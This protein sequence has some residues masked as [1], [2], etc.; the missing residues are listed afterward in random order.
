MADRINVQVGFSVD[1]NGLTQ[2]QSLF[3]QIVNE[4]KKPGQ[5][6]NTGLQKAATTAR[7][8]D[9]ILEKTFNSD[10]GSLNVTKFNQELSKTGLSLKSIKNDFSNAGS[11]GSMAYNRLT[12]SILGTNIQLKQSNKLLDSMAVSMSNTVK[13]GITSSIFNTITQSISKAVTYVKQLD[14]SLNDIR[15]V[16][17]KSADNMAEFA[18]QANIAAKEMG[19]STLDYTNAALIYYQQGLSDE[20]T[21]ARAET[22]VKAANVT[23]QTGQEVSE[24][25]TAVW[26]GYKV[27]AEET[28]LYVDKLAAVA[29]TTA[30]DLE[31]LSVGMSKVAS[32]ANAMGVDFDDLNAQ[33]ATIVSVTRQAPESVG[34]AL[35]TI[36]ARLGDLKVDGVDEFGIK[37]GEV[38]SQLQAMGIDILDVNGD[39]R[40]M[41]SVMTE[42][43]E[44]W[45][46][47]TRSQQQAAAIAMAGKRQYNNLIAL[48]ENWDMYSDA[49]KTSTDAMGTLQHQQDIYMESTEA[50]LKTLK[51]TWQDLYGG[52]IKKDELDT[53]IEAL[54]NL[55]QVFDNFIDSFGG[56]IKSIS[57]FGIIIANIFNKQISDSINNAIQNQQRYQQNIDLLI[58]KQKSFEVGALSSGSSIRDQ[59]IQF[60]TQKELDIA[61]EI[62]AVKVGLNTEDYNNLTNMQQRVGQLSEEAK[63]IE[64]ITVQEEQRNLSEDK[65]NQLLTEENSKVQEILDKDLDRYNIKE[66]DLITEQKKVDLIE[67]QINKAVALNAQEKSLAG[68]K[69]VILNYARSIGKEEEEEISKILQNVNNTQDLKRLKEYI[70]EAASGQVEKEAAILNEID[71]EIAAENRVLEKREQIAKYQEEEL[72]LQNQINQ[73]IKQGAQ[74]AG[75]TKTVTTIT[76]SLSSMAMAWGSVNS[77]IDTLNDK[78]ASFGDKITQTFM[79]LGMTIPMMLSSFSKI[80]EAFNLTSLWDAYNAKV[81]ASVLAEKAHAASIAQVTLAKEADVAMSQLSCMEDEKEVGV[82]LSK[83]SAEQMEAISTG[84]QTVAEIANSI[85]NQEGIFLDEKQIAAIAAVIMAKNAEAAATDALTASEEASNFAAKQLNATLLASPIGW[86]LGILAAVVAVTAM[87]VK[88]QRELLQSQIDLNNATIERANKLQEEVDANEDLINE[89]N[90]LYSQYKQGKIEKE[91]LYETTDK[92]CD[93]Y[94]IE[95]GYLAKLTGDYDSLTDSINKAREAELESIIQTTKAEKAA[96][97]ANILNTGRQGLGYL[98]G[99]QYHIAF[100]SDHDNRNNIKAQAELREQ[101]LDEGSFGISVGTDAQS[102]IDLYNKVVQAKTAMDESMTEE[103]RSYSDTYQHVTEWIDKMTDS[104]EKLQNATEQLN[105]YKIQKIANSLDLSNTSSY[106]DFI[107]KL[108]SFRDKLKEEELDTELTVNELVEQYLGDL[109]SNY[110]NIYLGLKDLKNQID[111]SGQKY[112]DSLSEGEKEYLL[113]GKVNLKFVQ[114]AEDIQ[115]EL[116]LSFDNLGTFDVTTPISLGETLASGSKLK[117][118]DNQAIQGLI[119]ENFEAMA[120][121]DEKSTLHQLDVIDEITQHRIDKN[122]EYLQNF[123]EVNKK[124]QSIREEEKTNLE[125]NIEFRQL[126]AAEQRRNLTEEET[127]KLE[128]YRKKIQDVEEEILNLQEKLKEGLS[129]D[130]IEEIGFDSLIS[131]ID[132]VI[133]RT[134]ALQNAAELVGENFVVAASDVEKLSNVF[135]ELLENYTV[136]TDGSLQLDKDLVQEK[137]NGIKTEM[138]ARTEAKIAEI[139]QQIEL[140]KLEQE[141]LQKKLENLQTYLEGKQSEQATIDAINKAGQEYEAGLMALTG[142]EITNLTNHAIASSQSEGATLIGMLNQVGAGFAQAAK[143]H[144]AMINGENFEWEP[145][146]FSGTSASAQEYASNVGKQAQALYEK[147]SAMYEQIFEEAKQVQN[148]LNTVNGEID[149]LVKQK[150]VLQSTSSA[151]LHALDNVSSGKAGKDSKSKKGGGGK[152]KKDKDEKDYEKEFDR[153]WKI[154]KA[155]DAVD[156]ALKILEKDKKN[157][158]GYQLI[159]A[160]KYENKLLD[161][162][163]GYYKQLLDAQEQ[164]AAELRDQLGTMGLMFD[165]SGAIVNYAEATAKALAQYN[166][167]I[168]QY[169]AGLIDETTLGVYEKSFE[170]FKKL[171]ERYDTLYYKEIKDTKDKLDDIRR[172]ELENNL[173]AWEVEIKLKLDLKELKRGWNDFLKEISEDFQK[174][175]KD[176]TVETKRLMDD[177]KTYIGDDGSIKTIINAIH[178]VTHEIDVMNSGGKSTMFESIT[179]AQEKL[180]ELN[181]ELQDAAKGL[182]DLWK[183]AWDA[184]LDGIDQVSDKLEDLMNQFDRINDELEFQGELIELIYGDEAYELLNKLYKGQE[185][186]LGNQI[187]SLKLQVDMWKQLFE[188]TGAAMDNQ[189]NWT[190]DQKAY[191]DKWMDAQSDLNDLVIDYIKLLKEDYLNTVSLVLKELENAITGSSLD[192]VKTQWERIS[193]Y[194]DKYLD[195]VEG[196]YEIQKLA[197]KIDESIANTDNLKQQQKLQALREKEI[198]Y[199]REKEHLTQ[200][201]LDAAE[202]RYQIALKEMALEDARNNKTSMK[203]VRNE[204]GNWAYQYVADEA[205]VASKQQELLD[206]FNNL[207]Q[208]ASDAYE[209][210]LEALQELQEKYLESAQ[211]IYENEN[212][213]EQEKE[214]QL[215][216][217]REWYFEQYA[218]LAE[219]NTLY[220]N[221]LATSAAA[222]LLEIYEQDKEAYTALTEEER[223]LL[224]A[225]VQANIDDYMDLEEKMKENYFN[226]GD[227]SRT[228]MA[229]TRLDWT[230]TAQLLADLWN[231]DAGGSVRYEVLDAYNRIQR[232]TNDYKLQLDWLAAAAAR[233]FGPEG[234]TG[235]IDQA[236]NATDN[237]NLKTQ[238]LVNDGVYYLSILKQAVDQIAAAWQSVQN[239]IT[240]AISLLEKYISMISHW[241]AAVE[242]NT[243]RQGSG[244]KTTNTVSSG[245]GSGNGGGGGGTPTTGAGD[246]SQYWTQMDRIIYHQYEENTAWREQ[247]ARIYHNPNLHYATG[248]YTGSWASGDTDGRLAVLHQKEIVLNKDDTANFLQAIN[249]VRDLSG[250]NDSI[251][252]TI[253]NSIASMVTSMINPKAKTGN[254]TIITENSSEKNNVFNI[255]AEFPNANDVNEIR[256]A[257]MSLPNMASQYIGRNV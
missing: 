156:R 173:K 38:S 227:A 19:A 151:A 254:G 2:M 150:A 84:E 239:E 88:R 116:Q 185:K 126:E 236:A 109:D 119:D 235:A 36:Y 62:Y 40:D 201:D 91:A 102:L 49:L 218:L 141:Y 146:N 93:L 214:E 48:F 103:E 249:T 144:Y 209:A 95:G 199:L 149:E 128:E 145:L 94:N 47:W 226:I 107:N 252:S 81:T 33:I 196:A 4:A 8:L 232:A 195:D 73:G 57:A 137:V 181:D 178:D 220:R 192:R 31:E 212:L 207:Y 124:I 6:L 143:A 148:Q 10:L 113:S 256:E 43:A 174:V 1:K 68:H 165:A 97:E 58:E 69:L 86:I 171:L 210:N 41:T 172:K 74:G 243:T 170:N 61:K 44:K 14:T 34:T 223:A 154:K 100:T 26:N 250:L 121:F 231:K 230:S 130:E 76:S 108:N 64:L 163:A 79:T 162:Q 132:M 22:T 77:L 211:E 180:K 203:L 167:A 159:D 16:T 157:L 237:L 205:E 197:N 66:Q 244:A 11:Q 240:N 65:I 9:N 253:M 138:E 98:A 13:W 191:Y 225:L 245:N 67:Q 215:L 136:L 114:T 30:A 23:G 112:I 39:M 24:Q 242:E 184:Y 179:Q 85:A 140:K 120:G 204:Q 21:R 139:D 20:E 247:Q 135:P 104:V 175:Y 75:V 147:N 202:A 219:E 164:E 190:E 15:I 105:D 51:A 83:I 176:L 71:N 80:R 28:E 111:E 155:I 82:I 194:T 70:L 63:Y 5:E 25:L 118:A 56:G 166:A 213:S 54:T 251:S 37:L 53:G 200:Y 18:E 241:N 255:T 177:A 160:L 46:T 89:Y 52:L 248:G 99:G 27:T 182:H 123:E 208:L 29:A 32:A 117:K 125:G 133:N 168:Q 142:Q 50:K 183:D 110:G 45:D 92:L 122:N 222:L 129:F 161:E 17:D 234:I 55:I 224:D 198:G 257:I 59:A 193:A 229:E 217:L 206:A 42:V 238:Q 228:M 131:G 216:E 106:D 127:E 60:G 187:Q 87:V 72:I 233:D 78:T 101:G 134:D 115:K 158:Y 186:S 3:Q 35:K 152:D 246:T 96:A 7:T 12:Q 90:K 169:N 221:D 153:Y 189:E 188:A